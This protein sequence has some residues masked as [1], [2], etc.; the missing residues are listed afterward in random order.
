MNAGL[1]ALAFGAFAIGVTEFTPMGLLPNIAAGLGVSIPAAGLLV[2]AYAAG[3]MIGA[4]LVTLVLGTISRRSALVLLMIVYTLGNVSSAISPSYQFLMAARLLTRL[5]HGAFFGI[6]VTLAASLAPQG[7]GAASVATMLMGLTVANIG[8]V[9]AA[10]WLGQGVGW[11]ASFLGAGVLGLVSL[12]WLHASLP[13]EA[14]RLRPAVR[15]E[16]QALARPEVVVGLLTTVFLA[17]SMFTLYTYVAAIL[18]RLVR[19]DGTFV[20][21]MLIVIGVGFSI[22]NVVSGRLT[23]RLPVATLAG[24]L[25]LLGCTSFAV[26]ILGT[27]RSGATLVLLVWGAAA[28]ASAI[29][30]QM[31][32][33]KAAH[34]AP[35]LASSVNIGAFNLGN[36]LGAAVGG[37]TL[38]LGFEKLGRE[39]P[40]MVRPSASGSTSVSDI[41]APARAVIPPV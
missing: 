4:P 18:A 15:R 14:A 34:D 2:S 6:G 36:E 41:V 11:R 1:A 39:P 21:L 29:P 37:L 8:G 30:V 3:V 40:F 5:S 38:D 32:V 10:T 19:A 33:M 20:T 16:L 24:G 22:G 13:D 7:R 9:P 28:F 26:P 23:D 27:T 17:G 35:A 25:L 12:A 31:A